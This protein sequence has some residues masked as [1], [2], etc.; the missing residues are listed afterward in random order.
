MFAVLAKSA[1]DVPSAEPRL[2]GTPNKQQLPVLDDEWRAARLRVAPQSRP[3]RHA[4][5]RRRRRK[6]SA[7]LDAI[8]R[9]NLRANPKAAQDHREP[10]ERTTRFGT[11]ERS[12][13][14]HYGMLDRPRSR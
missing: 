8:H 1:G 5:R 9:T 11:T 6:P 12:S 7:T 14:R 2:D 4:L 10:P 13:T 3:T